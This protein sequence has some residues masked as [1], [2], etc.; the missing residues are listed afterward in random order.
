MYH[1]RGAKSWAS[2]AVRLALLALAL[3]LGGMLPLLSYHRWCGHLSQPGR[4][5]PRS[6]KPRSPRCPQRLLPPLRRHLWRLGC[7]HRSHSKLG[8]QMRIQRPLRR[9]TQSL[10]SSSVF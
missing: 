4:V 5:L 10:S 6:P 2:T 7:P 9:A 8:Q 3:A 1:Q